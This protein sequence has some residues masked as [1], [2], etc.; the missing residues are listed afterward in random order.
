M[1]HTGS[2]LYRLLIFSASSF[3]VWS[4]MYVAQVEKCTCLVV[5]EFAKP[6][7]MPGIDGAR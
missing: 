3:T 6:W 5:Q 4:D 1:R 2:C 7:L